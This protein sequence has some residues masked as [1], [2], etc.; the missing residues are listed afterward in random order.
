MYVCGRGICC[1]D[2]ILAVSRRLHWRGARLR[3]EPSLER[4]NIVPRSGRAGGRAKEDET[5]SRRGCLPEKD[6]KRWWQIRTVGSLSIWPCDGV[7]I[8]VVKSERWKSADTR[9]V[10]DGMVDGG[11]WTVDGGRWTGKGKRQ[12][13]DVRRAALD[14]G[15]DPNNRHISC[16]SLSISISIWQPA[17][18][19]H[20]NN[21]YH[22][23]YRLDLPIPNVTM[24]P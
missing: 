6:W 23:Q 5:V 10:V 7:Y 12:L 8:V 3:D 21:E 18:W 16:F 11:R 1:W 19:Y 22:L 15:S 2:R 14:F 20:P 9:C 17:A 13:Q 4:A 24:I